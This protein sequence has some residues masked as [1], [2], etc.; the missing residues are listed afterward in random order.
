M[1]YSFRDFLDTNQAVSHR[2][3]NEQNNSTEWNI[4]QA[5]NRIQMFSM[6]SPKDTMCLF[7]PHGVNVIFGIFEPL[8]QHQFEDAECLGFCV[9]EGIR[10]NVF[11]APEGC[12]LKPNEIAVVQLSNGVDYKTML[13]PVQV[14]VSMSETYPKGSPRYYG[15]VEF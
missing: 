3:K 4:V 6:V 8:I 1:K 9:I 5:T 12:H 14:N 10:Y 11:E 13:N 7:F 2:I 15:V